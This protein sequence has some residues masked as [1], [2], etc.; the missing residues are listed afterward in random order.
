MIEQHF[1]ESSEWSVGVEEEVMILDGETFALAPEVEAM[2][3]ASQG[4]ELPGRLKP[5]LFA[6]VV[7]L[8]TNACATAA[9]ALEALAELR[10]SAA[11]IAEERGLLIAAAGSH[12]FSLAEEQAIAPDP[13]YEEFVAYAGP[14]ARRQGVS[15]LHVHIGMPDAETCFAT[16]GAVLPWL[17]LVLALSANSPYFDGRETGLASN[18]AEVLAQLPRSG[19]P[20]AFRSYLEWESFVERYVQLGLADGYTRFWWDIRPHPSL[21]TL[22]IRMPDQPTRLEVSGALIAVVQ[23]LCAVLAGTTPRPTAAARG[24]YAQNRWAALRFGP[25]AEFVHP[26][27]DRL[28][29]VAELTAELV[30]LIAPAVSSLGT[31]ALVESLDALSCEGDRQL[32]IGR[33]EGS[34]AVCAD[35][36]Q[37]TVRSSA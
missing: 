5:E 21:G 36:V 6:S 27:G 30:E 23:A 31:A 34:K 11:E 8:N 7:E 2:I 14:S 3:D 32:E 33:R 37:R 10:G 29:S 13:R 22:E 19:A 26:E 12:P 1:G 18:R 20:P 17:P 16:L 35:L 25:R 4:R 24:G 9:E 15:G 28:V